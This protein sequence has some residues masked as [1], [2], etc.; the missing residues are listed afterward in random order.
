LA[1]HPSALKR[2]K[3]S[4]AR[5]LRN[6][7]IR[8]RIKTTVKKFQQVLETGTVESARPLMIQA[9]AQIDRAGSQGVVHPRTASRKISRLAKKLHRRSVQP[10]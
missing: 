8:S 3:Q 7:S 1:N 5:R 6:M 10:A 9:I 4:Q 2:V